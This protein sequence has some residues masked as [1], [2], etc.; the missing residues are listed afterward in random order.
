MNRNLRKISITVDPALLDD[1]DYV[2]KRAGVSR[3]ALISGLLG[4]ILPATRELFE[5][6]PLNP[7]PADVVRFRGE[8]ADI[9]RARLGSIRDLDSDLFSQIMDDGPAGG[10]K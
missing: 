7:E 10:S 5:K 2:S 3:S 9:V 1:L 4:E 8:S 6:V